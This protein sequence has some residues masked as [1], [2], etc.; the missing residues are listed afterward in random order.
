MRA[1]G[2]VLEFD[3]IGLTRKLRQT[4]DVWI[5]ALQTLRLTCVATLLLV[6]ENADRS[7]S[8][9]VHTDS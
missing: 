7:L 6:T 4:R 5:Y 8:K 3:N 1:R 9:N 2:V